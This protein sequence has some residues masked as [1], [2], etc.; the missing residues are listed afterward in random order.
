MGA[1]WLTVVANITADPQ[2]YCR[3]PSHG[4]ALPGLMV[5]RAMQSIA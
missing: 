4:G 1:V 5:L 2:G 3:W